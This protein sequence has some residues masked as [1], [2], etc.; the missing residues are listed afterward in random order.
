M[1]NKIKI[2]IINGPNL[3][4][5][6]KREPSV[7]G[8]LSLEKIIKYTH[9]QLIKLGHKNIELEWFQS[10]IEGEIINKI[11]AL[12][13]PKSDFSALLINPGAY[14]HTSIAILDALKLLDIPVIEVHLSQIFQREAFRQ[15][16]ITAQAAQ[17]VISGAGKQAYLLGI[18]AHLF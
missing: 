8:K 11:Q 12:S 10:N 5:L 3:N 13:L 4:M 1:K 14:S 9:Q 7:Y 2:L 16:L 18:L 15:N 17:K 6:G